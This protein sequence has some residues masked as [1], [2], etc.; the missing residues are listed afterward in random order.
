MTYDTE[1]TIEL[2]RKH[3]KTFFDNAGF[4]GDKSYKFIYEDNRRLLEVDTELTGKVYYEIGENYNLKYTTLSE[5]G[6]KRPIY[7]SNGDK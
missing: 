1:L 5:K 7:Q 3:N 2:L 6:F 4:H